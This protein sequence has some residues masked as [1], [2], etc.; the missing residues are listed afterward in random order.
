[1]TG[2]QSKELSSCDGCAGTLVFNCTHRKIWDDGVFRPSEGC[3]GWHPVVTEVTP[4]PKPVKTIQIA[5]HPETERSWGA[6]YA[7][8]DD[9]SIWELVM[10]RGSE[11][12]DASDK[13]E[14]VQPIP[15]EEAE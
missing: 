6:L 11:H 4:V 2:Q 10:T 5:A 8:R 3:P 7:L 13:W 1:M 15:D 12:H 14:K 9:G